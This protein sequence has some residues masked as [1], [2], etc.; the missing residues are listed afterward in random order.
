MKKFIALVVVLCTVMITSFT[1]AEAKD[2][3]LYDGSVSAMTQKLEEIPGI[4][5]WGLEER[6][7]K[8]VSGYIGHFGDNE[9]NQLTFLVNDDNS[10]KALFVESQFGDDDLVLEQILKLACG[11][12]VIAG[13]TLDDVAKLMQ[14]MMSDMEKTLSKNSHLKKYEQSFS[15]YSA[16]DK[17]E[18]VV[19]FSAREIT[20]DFG[21]F[22]FIIFA[23]K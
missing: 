13:V 23:R 4:K 16:Q 3:P 14:D 17:R 19:N 11:T 10:I 22:K 7:V 12:L 5:I 9:K 18:L 6:I 21:E 1:S 8:G 20:D 2:V 15:A